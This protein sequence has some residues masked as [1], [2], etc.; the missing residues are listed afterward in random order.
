MARIN[1]LPWRQEERKRKNNE[2]NRLMAAVAGLAIVTVALA[3]TLLNNDLS[4]QQTANK[5]IEEANAQLDIA[6]KSIETLE[7][8]REQMLSQ[9]KVIQDLQ[10]RRSI[11]VRVWDDIA[12]AVP[13]AMYL[14]NIKREDDLIT[15]TGYADNANIVANLVRNL[16]NS[17]WLDGSAVVSIKSKLEA[18]QNTTTA[19]AST[20]NAD[21][22][23]LRPSYPEDNYVEFVVTTKVQQLQS[24]QNAEQ[25]GEQPL[26]PAENMPADFDATIAQPLGVEP[27][28]SEPV[29]PA[30]NPQAVAPTSTNLPTDQTAGAQ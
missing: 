4:N 6:L 30:S 23:A 19:A 21:G 3:Y 18:Y 17:E 14:V 8:Q 9:M 27:V 12:R 1:L 2:F 10:G 28:G 29:A 15:I 16:N 25:S 26:L 7:A 20:K 24:D 13:M 22:T 5:K 11:P